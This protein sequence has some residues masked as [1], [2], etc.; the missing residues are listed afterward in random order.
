MYNSFD[1]NNEDIELLYNLASKWNIPSKFIIKNLINDKDLKDVKRYTYGKKYKFE[2]V[3]YYIIGEINKN[4]DMEDIIAYLEKYKIDLNDILMFYIDGETK[5][6]EKD[7]NNFYEIDDNIIKK[8][9]DIISRSDS[10]KNL[11]DDYKNKYFTWKKAFENLIEEDK[12]KLRILEEQNKIFNFLDKNIPYE[13]KVH[14]SPFEENKKLIIVKGF[15]KENK[16]IIINEEYGNDIFDNSKVSIY[17]PF[18][19]YNDESLNG[20]YK[21]YND[22]NLNNK[23]DF[24]KIILDKNITTIENTIYFRLWHG[25]EKRVFLKDAPEK[26]FTTVI[27]NLRTNILKLTIPITN[28]DHGYVNEEIL[29]KRIQDAFPKIDFNFDETSQQI[30]NSDNESNTKITGS[31]NMYNVEFDETSFLHMF[32]LYDIMNIYFYIDETEKATA[33]RKSIILE[34]RGIFTGDKP[35]SKISLASLKIKKKFFLENDTFKIYNFTDNTITPY[36]TKKKLDYL[37]LEVTSPSKDVIIMVVSIFQKLMTFYKLHNTPLFNYYANYIP[38]L[39]LLKNQRINSDKNF[40]RADI[41][42]KILTE[43]LPLVFNNYY[44]RQCQNYVPTH[45]NDNQVEEYKKQTFIKKL[46]NDE[47]K[48]MTVS[49]KKNK[50]ISDIPSEKLVNRQVLKYPA[51]NS[52]LNLVCNYEEHPYPGVK[53]NIA[54]NTEGYNWIPCCF[55]KDK[56]GKNDINSK[57][58][59]YLRN[60]LP[61]NKNNFV[62]KSI[63]LDPNIANLLKNNQDDIIFERFTI[64]QSINSLIDAIFTAFSFND[65]IKLLTIDKQSIIRNYIRININEQIIYLQ[66]FRKQLINTIYLSSL[67]QE[68]YD[69]SEEEIK[70]LFNDNN[71]IFEYKLLYRVLEIYFDINIYVFTGEGYNVS[72]VIPNNK[73]LHIRPLYLKNTIILYESSDYDYHYDLIIRKYTNTQNIDSIFKNTIKSDFIENDINQLCHSILSYTTDN[74]SFNYHENKILKQKNMYY[75]NYD[76]IF[77]TKSYMISYDSQFIDNNGKTRALNVS[78]NNINITLCI[79]PT[80]PFNIPESK[81]LA[82]NIPNTIYIDY[83]QL[84][85][86]IS[87]KPFGISR[88]KDNIIDGLWYPLNN[89]DFGIFIHIKEPNAENLEE[90]KTLQILTNIKYNPLISNN[91]NYTTT[92]INM[93]RQ[94]NIII[95]IIKWSYDITYKQNPRITVDQFF[96]NYIYTEILLNNNTSNYDLSKIPYKLPTCETLED[97][98]K[99]LYS[100]VNSNNNF[101]VKIKDQYKLRMYNKIFSDKIYELLTDYSEII[102]PS[103]FKIDSS[104]DFIKNYFVYVHDYKQQY[105]ARIFLNFQELE[106]WKITLNISSNILIKTTINKELLSTNYNFIYKSTINRLYIVQKTYNGSLQYALFISEYWQNNKINL[107]MEKNVPNKTT[108][109]YIVYT[110]DKFNKITPLDNNLDKDDSTT[111]ACEILFLGDIHLYR[112]D[113]RNYYPLLPLQ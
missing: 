46:S 39:N 25:D 59:K 69:H 58:N 41:E 65:N 107:G 113:N 23:V 89:I 110:L 63:K 104:Y 20:I 42:L 94:L 66:D 109:K 34:Y 26:S 73:L 49:N 93:K 75:L 15:L 76:T 36:I 56:I 91:I 38:N 67:K 83:N 7:G 16:K 61:D 85:H 111:N 35:S 8:L 31:V 22:N 32:L 99:T 27:Y 47:K 10:D 84:K 82:S 101:I 79:P 17:I 96:D 70:H 100:I 106:K 21:I 72:M 68:L 92:V 28:N 3:K 33:F 86:L 13:H 44:K 87:N 1:V 64:K 2:N 102:R 105:N 97:S 103:N 11:L 30:S 54:R 95:N 78:I 108:N 55:Q 48:P 57:Y 88:N 74:I 19:C 98:L 90:F 51:T 53:D 5:I 50:N 43:K 62:S 52:V 14:I 29:Y 112:A 77:N 12:K 9:K 18:I 45:I 71:T 24:K 60:E 81:E 80:Q 4:S 40:T 6:V 37:T